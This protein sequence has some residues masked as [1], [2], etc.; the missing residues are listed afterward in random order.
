MPHQGEAACRG[1]IARR[2]FGY[3]GEGIGAP[4][5]RWHASRQSPPG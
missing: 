2:D 4:R 1:P 3:D 5:A